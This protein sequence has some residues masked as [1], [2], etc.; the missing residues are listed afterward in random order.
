M[1]LL[2]VLRMSADEAARSAIA[3]GRAM[4]SANAQRIG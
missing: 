3:L 2:L 4:N 1:L